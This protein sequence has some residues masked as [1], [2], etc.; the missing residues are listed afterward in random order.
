VYDY[1]VVRVV[2]HVEREEFIN[3][4]I[5]LFCRP[6]RY[7]AAKVELDCERL[8]ALAP[9]CDISMVQEQLAL[10]PRLCAGEGPI[11]R[12]GQAE[13]YHWL[14]APHST[15]IQCSPVHSGVTDDLPG[16]LERL[17]ETMV[18]RDGRGQSEGGNEG[19]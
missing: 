16:T 2:P 12:L 4:G 9:N 7:L 17:M 13:T 8:L 6:A 5:I 18:R 19:F 3:A 10:I 14:V 1:A 15:V 11:G